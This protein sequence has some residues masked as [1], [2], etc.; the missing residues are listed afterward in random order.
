M[1]ICEWCCHLGLPSGYIYKQPSY[2]KVSQQDFTVINVRIV[3][4]IDD[5][6]LSLIISNEYS[7]IQAFIHSDCIKK[8]C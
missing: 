6:K 7:I 5:L 1:A 8:I 3:L 4:H 2:S